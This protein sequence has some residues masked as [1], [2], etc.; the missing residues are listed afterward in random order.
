MAGRSAG[1]RT[2]W[3]SGF[4]ASTV[5]A[6]P[7]RIGQRAHQSYQEARVAEEPSFLAEVALT[8]TWRGSGRSIEISG[9]ADGLFRRADGTL[10]VEE[11]KSGQEDA[12]VADAREFAHCQA[13]L[14]AWLVEAERGEACAAQVV[15][16]DPSGRAIARDP[17]PR[18]RRRDLEQRIRETL[19]A[20][21]EE[22]IEREALRKRWRESVGAFRTP[23]ATWR[24]EQ[25]PILDAVRSAVREEGQLLLEAPTG[26]GKTAAVCFA[27]LQ[28]AV[29][30]GRPVFYLTPKRSQQ[31][32]AFR[33][34]S[35]IV[36][37]SDI[38]L[39][40]RGARHTLC[41]T[42]RNSC[43][44]CERLAG[45]VPTPARLLAEA[46]S[47]ALD[48][49]SLTRRY[50]DPPH[51]AYWVARTL[52]REV[53]VVVGDYDLLLRGGSFDPPSA[54]PLNATRPSPLVLIDEIHQLPDRARAFF[55]VELDTELLALALASLANSSA[56]SAV[57][58]RAALEDLSAWIENLLETGDDL[59]RGLV[60]EFSEED[61][62][63]TFE[64]FDFAFSDYCAYGTDSGLFAFSE[65]P[66][67]VVEVGRTLA[68]L[69]E[70]SRREL[71]G[72]RRVGFRSEGRR[73]VGLWCIDPAPLLAR[74]MERC[75]AVIGWSATLLSRRDDPTP[76]GLDSQRC[77]VLRSEGS[78]R[79][80]GREVLLDA[81][82]A[83]EHRRWR[84]SLP[85]LAGS[86]RDLVSSV[87][88]HSAIFVPSFK[89]LDALAAELE[90]L[91]NLLRQTREQS[92][93]EREAQIAA[94]AADSDPACLLAVL[95][96]AFAEGVDYS[97]GALSCVAVVG[98]PVP[99]PSLHAELRREA[100]EE[101]GDDGF[102]QIYA[103]PAVR[104]A[105]QAA[106]RLWRSPDDTGLLVL[107][108][109]RF[110]RAP[111][112]ELLPED[113]RDPTACKGAE[114]AA[115]ARRFFDRLSC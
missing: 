24:E 45:A 82:V 53:P 90:G 80:E 19:D 23:F 8:S 15:W 108:G 68:E 69:A 114:L 65:G 39:L 42:G 20:C 112:A 76:Y 30:E 77:G 98:P 72:L 43:Q 22:S 64:A 6:D 56:R 81:S 47:Q 106:G 9:R 5:A 99:P 40:Q 48:R 63:A 55:G 91:P 83:T 14:Y 88:G 87:P 110:A 28:A 70:A 103:E 79:G 41:S 2:A 115:A 36:G 104:A 92:D 54:F 12:G 105:R 102:E 46:P 73:G 101:A 34:I 35:R 111:Y 11:L 49:R 109:S 57:Q 71:P 100:L 97:G 94:L 60:V 51:C 17:L 26:S 113:W 3:P 18:V 62:S 52:T 27:A 96:G 78:I 75:G 59:G 4:S 38:T 32:H 58:M 31:T 7:R 61:P 33:E 66:D 29:Q 85:R 93:S 13:E 44:E 107:L 25:L 37:D 84:K 21:L 74:Q 67:P 10:C 89:W 86:L 1:P 50:A 16:I 95:S